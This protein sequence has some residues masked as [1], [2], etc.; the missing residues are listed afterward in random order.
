MFEGK[1]KAIMLIII[2]KILSEILEGGE[3]DDEGYEIFK[4]Y[5]V[6]SGYDVTLLDT[7][8]LVG[9]LQ[10]IC[11]DFGKLNLEE[12]WVGEDES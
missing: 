5:F 4:N 9:V 7:M 2:I 10:I 8:P 6:D 11:R 1:D 12:Y 3:M